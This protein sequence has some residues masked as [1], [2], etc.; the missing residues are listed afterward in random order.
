MW[1]SSKALDFQQKSESSASVLVSHWQKNKDNEAR[2]STSQAVL[3]RSTGRTAPGRT[4][5]RHHSKC[6]TTGANAHTPAEPCT[7]TTLPEIL[8]KLSH[9]SEA[10]WRAGQGA[11]PGQVKAKVGSKIT[12]RLLLLKNTR[13]W[14]RGRV[15]GGGG[16]AVLCHFHQHILQFSLSIKASNFVHP[17]AGMSLIWPV[18][19][20]EGTQIF[21]PFTA[22]CLQTFWAESARTSLQ[23]VYF[24]HLLSILCALMEI[25]L[26]AS[27]KNKKGYKF[28]TF[29]GH[30]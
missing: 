7:D 28:C 29:N 13:V 1:K 8:G 22:F 15:G 4:W 6:T 2:D 20:T 9:H 3:T 17:G 11:N 19:W 24:S 14:G 21:N 12:A 27:V 16:G 23:T 5:R 18:F 25:F 30:F 10:S 26:H